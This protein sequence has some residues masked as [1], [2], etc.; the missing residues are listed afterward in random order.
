MSAANLLAR[1]PFPALSHSGRG[2]VPA[3]LWDCPPPV[4]PVESFDAELP[5]MFQASA[6]WAGADYESIVSHYEP[7]LNAANGAVLHFGAGRGEMMDTL[8]QHGF[9]VMG[10]ESSVLRVERARRAYG[11][12]ARTLQCC[13]AEMF[14]RWVRRIGQKAQAVFFRHDLEHSLELHALLRRMADILCENGRLI[15]LLPPPEA[16]HIREA[17]LSFL[18]ELAVGCASCDGNF[19]VESIDCDFENRFMA[20][21][22]KKAAILG[23]ASVGKSRRPSVCSPRG[24]KTMNPNSTPDT[25]TPRGEMT[26]DMD[27]A[28]IPSGIHSGRRVSALH[29]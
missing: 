7:R 2:A 4:A 15:A 25:T 6:R 5:E 18:N 28:A 13:N 16:D 8:R 11:F 20:F 1:E 22:L 12:D 19:E 17:H 21:V 10:C 26:M 27:T 23:N 29:S 14:L 24:V 9:T 3:F